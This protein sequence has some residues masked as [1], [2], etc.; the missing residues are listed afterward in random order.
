MSDLA[1]KK[2]IPCSGDTPPLEPLRIEELLPQLDAWRVDES[3][4]LARAYRFRD[5][6]EAFDLVRRVAEIAEREGHHPEIRFGWGHVD[7]EVWT[8]AIDGLTESDFVLAA[9]IDEAARS[10][11]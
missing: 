1:A 10:G 6:A 7:L 2:C 8:H 3:G 11:Q 4:H 9:K 5:F